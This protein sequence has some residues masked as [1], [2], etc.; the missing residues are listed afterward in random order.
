LSGSLSGG[1][2]RLFRGW[3]RGSYE[4]ADLPERNRQRCEAKGPAGVDVRQD[5]QG[6]FYQGPVGVRPGFD[7]FRSREVVGGTPEYLRGELGLLVVEV[8]AQ[9][10]PRER[11][12]AV[13]AGQ[14][15]DMAAQSVEPQ[16]AAQGEIDHRHLHGE[17]TA[18][19]TNRAYTGPVPCAVS[20][21]SM[22][23]TSSS[24]RARS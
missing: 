23:T 10:R 12:P 5:L 9:R 21:T 20:S 24:R 13:V 7:A 15:L 2:F 8:V 14:G 16:P 11:L 19:P 22:S 4:V 17:P 3:A 6:A 18:T 1:R